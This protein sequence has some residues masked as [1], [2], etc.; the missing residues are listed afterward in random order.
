MTVPD[1]A[2]TCRATRAAHGLTQEQAARTVGVT[3]STWAAWEQGRRT[4]TTLTQRGVAA[5]LPPS[6]APGP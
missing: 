1:W 6:D 4:P 5:L 2:T 3:V